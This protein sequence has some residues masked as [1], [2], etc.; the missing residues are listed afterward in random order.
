LRNFSIS[1]ILKTI[2]RKLNHKKRAATARLKENQ[3]SED[4]NAID[5]SKVADEVAQLSPDQIKE[6]LTA[7]RVRQKVQQKKQ[8]A[9]GGQKAYN[10]RQAEYRRQLK[11]KA[12]ELGLYDEIT[13]DA[14]AKA[15]T[16]YAAEVGEDA[17]EESAA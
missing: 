9:K 15:E 5:L 14:D 8:A 6:K 1:R 11:E 7:I 17:T 2:E 16:Q 3:M 10:Q 13:A 12:I 4:T